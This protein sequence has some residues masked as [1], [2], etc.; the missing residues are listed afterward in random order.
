M[1]SCSVYIKNGTPYLKSRV[2][3]HKIVGLYLGKV[4]K[5]MNDAIPFANR[6]DAE[7]PRLLKHDVHAIYFYNNK[8]F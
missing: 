3:F 6:R 2:F 8:I 4:G 1:I 7:Q 5:E